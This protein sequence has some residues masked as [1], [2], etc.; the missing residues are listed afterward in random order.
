MSPPITNGPH[1]VVVINRTTV[2]AM[3][4]PKA[5]KK[6]ALARSGATCYPMYYTVNTTVEVVL[7]DKC[8]FFVTATA[9][10][11]VFSMI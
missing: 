10:A 8:W 5:P 4:K 11:A 7:V 3:R 1:L 2:I 6:Q 9:A